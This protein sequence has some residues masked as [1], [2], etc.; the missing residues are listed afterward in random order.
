MADA[1]Q[2]LP[3]VGGGDGVDETAEQAV[4]VPL[5]KLERGR[6]RRDAVDLRRPARARAGTAAAPLETDSQEAGPGEPVEPAARDRAM[7]VEARRHVVCAYG[8]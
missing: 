1:R 5:R 8:A 3:A 7:D 6:L 4:V 2:N